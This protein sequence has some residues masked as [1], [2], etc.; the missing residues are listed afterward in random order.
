MMTTTNKLTL[1]SNLK[2]TP[3][4]TMMDTTAKKI[5]NLAIMVMVVAKLTT[6][7]AKHNLQTKVKTKGQ[8]NQVVL[9]LVLLL[10][11]IE[12]FKYY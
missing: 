10:A 6:I 5:S 9:V 8:K 11:L 1:I 12:N 2:I 4:T 7:M 3:T